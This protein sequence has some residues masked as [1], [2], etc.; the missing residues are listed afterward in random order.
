MEK[1]RDYIVVFLNGQ[2]LH[3][4]G[5]QVFMMAAEYLRYQ[6]H[7]TGTKIVC[8][9]GDC[10][11]CTVLILRPGI[12][13]D[14][15]PINSCIVSMAQLDGAHMLTVEALKEGNKLSAV[16]EAIV[17]KHASQCGYCTPGFAMAITAMFERPCKKLD[18]QKVKN[19]LT[20]NLCRCTGYQPLIDA[21]LSVDQTKTQSLKERY[22]SDEAP[23]KELPIKLTHEHREF[24]APTTLLA[25]DQ[26]FEKNYTLF[27]GATDLG[28]L[29]NKG[30]AR[31]EGI[32]SLHLIKELYDIREE[33]NRIMVGARVTL[34]QVRTFCKNRVPSLAQ[35]INIFASP[36]IKNMATLVGNIANA[37]PIADTVPFMMVADGQV[38][39][40]GPEGARIIDMEDF[41]IAYKTL[42]LKPKEYISHV[43]FALPHNTYLKLDKISQRKDLDIASV[44][45]AFLLAKK[46]SEITKIKLALGGIGPV[47]KRL[48]N[49]ENFLMGQNLTHDLIGEAA[50]SIQKEITPLSDLRG[51]DHFR[52]VLVDGLFNRFMGAL[53]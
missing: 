20:G 18:S 30:K 37:S 24:R 51:S 2:R 14:F 26:L 49:T 6:K 29:L 12:D 39:V 7:L 1:T 50:K 21:A 3:L 8:A 46:G 35:F 38:H 27:C 41:Y 11:A 36:Q 9:E 43:S 16:Q 15:V 28:V 40:R 5:E 31:I 4:E 48:K 13:S 17:N 45:S 52:R 23:L 22:V 53:L 44:N 47:V 42:S 34:S 19:C 10:G 25:A 33:N 32:L